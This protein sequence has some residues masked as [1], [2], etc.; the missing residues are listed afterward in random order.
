MVFYILS[1]SRHRLLM[2]LL[3]DDNGLMGLLICAYH[4][5]TRG[6]FTVSGFG[7]PFSDFY[8]W[9]NDQQ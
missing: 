9:V 2:V 7:F 5:G 4:I 8:L 6:G 3:V 1:W